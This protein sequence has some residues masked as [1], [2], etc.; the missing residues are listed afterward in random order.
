MRYYSQLT[1]IALLTLPILQPEEIQMDVVNITLSN[2]KNSAN[3]TV[4]SRK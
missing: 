1:F 3:N 4:I 2:V